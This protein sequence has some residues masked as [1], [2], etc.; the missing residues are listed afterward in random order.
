M[1]GSP[2]FAI[3]SKFNLKNILKIISLICLFVAS[4]Q[5]LKNFKKRHLEIIIRSGEQLIFSNSLF[6]CRFILWKKITHCI[7]LQRIAIMWPQKKFDPIV[8]ILFAPCPGSLGQYSII[9][10]T[11]DVQNKL[12]SSSMS[13]SS[14]AWGMYLPRIAD[15]S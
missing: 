13:N 7:L 6:N 10:S 1:S 5:F 11:N 15:L 4:K 3:S 2:Y 8:C 12:S 14:D 9:H